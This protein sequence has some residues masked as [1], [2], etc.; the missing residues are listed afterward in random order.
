MIDPYALSEADKWD[1]KSLEEWFLFG[2]CV[3]GKGARQTAV[4]LDKFLKNV[5]NDGKFLYFCTTPFQYVRTLI[6]HGMLGS[7][8][9]K[10]KMGQYKRLN[11][12]FRGMVKI[13]PRTCTLEELEASHG[14]GP[15]TARMLLLYTRPD[16]KVVPLDTH[17]LKWLAARYDN[18]PKS[19]P[20]AG[21]RYRELEK[22]FIDEATHKGMTPKEL[23]MDVWLM[24]AN[25]RKETL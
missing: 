21:K 2:I 23:D 13:H 12:A 24:Y 22:L 5:I 25:K 19:T 10:H 15:K 7:E 8:L 18:V 11:K 14:V 17:I 1:D 16:M 3:A 9:W 6:E 4:K 20:P